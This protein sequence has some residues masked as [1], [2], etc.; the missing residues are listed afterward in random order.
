MI[1]VGFMNESMDDQINKLIKSGDQ[2]KLIAHL[3]SLGHGAVVTDPNDKGTTYHKASNSVKSGWGWRINGERQN[4]TLMSDA[5][6]AKA[7][8]QK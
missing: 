7:L 3:K 5:D 1:K 6:V 4:V 8:L 2:T